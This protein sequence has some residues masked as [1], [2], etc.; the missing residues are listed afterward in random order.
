MASTTR[1]NKKQPTDAPEEDFE[2][3]AQ[4]SLALLCEG[5]DKIIQDILKLKAKVQLNEGALDKIS[6]QFTNLN[7]SFED[8]EGELHD[9]KCKVH[10]IEV[11]DKY[12]MYYALIY[13]YLTY[14]CVLWSN[15]Y[16]AH[17]HNW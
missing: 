9:A 17:Y 3:F 2:A 13:P 7:Q 6:K 11:S 14:V 15:N 10:E 4:E 1:G 12:L 8:L 5:Q 16:E